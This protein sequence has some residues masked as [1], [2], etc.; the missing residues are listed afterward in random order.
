MRDGIEQQASKMT[1]ITSSSSSLHPEINDCVNV[2]VPQVDRPR[3]MSMQNFVGV[4]VAIEEK[5]GH[6]LYSVAT[7][8]GC[9]SP[10]LSRNQ[11]EICRRR[12]VIDIETV[13]RERTVS[14]RKIAAAEAI[15][16]RE[17]PSS[18]VCLC[19]IDSC[20]TMRCLCK[21]RGVLC[22]ERCRHGRNPKT[23]RINQ[24]IAVKFKCYN[25]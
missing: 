12:D 13:D 1:K 11:F 22:T 21:R 19:A 9:I 16:G 17:G 7:K 24:E 23:G 25:K 4:I 8:Y 3:K 6:K 5:K 2:T 10:L 15:K 20:R 14:I 18:K